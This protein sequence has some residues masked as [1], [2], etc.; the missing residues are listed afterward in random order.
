[1]A[2]KVQLQVNDQVRMRSHSGSRGYE[3]KT[4]IDQYFNREDGK[5]LT[6]SDL[7]E[8]GLDG[9]VDHVVI[10]WDHDSTLQYLMCQSCIF[11]SSD[12]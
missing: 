12:I 4:E 9:D 3:E 10:A 5:V 2:Q 11:W 6:G 7:A 1:M 8:L